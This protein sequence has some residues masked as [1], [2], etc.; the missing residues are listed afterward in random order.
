[1]PLREPGV[2]AYY[3]GPMIPIATQRRA[4]ELV[5]DMLAMLPWMSGKR[6]IDV[7]VSVVTELQ[8]T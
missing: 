4:R 7:T 6:D 5:A 3:M 2:D 1:M 8:M